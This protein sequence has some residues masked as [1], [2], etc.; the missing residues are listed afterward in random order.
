MHNFTAKLPLIAPDLNGIDGNYPFIGYD[1]KTNLLC[2]VLAGV[3]YELNG[4]ISTYQ[5]RYGNFNVGF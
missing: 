3:S 4:F 1:T 2:G 5:K